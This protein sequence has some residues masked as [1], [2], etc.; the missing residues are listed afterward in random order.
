MSKNFHKVRFLEIGSGEMD[1]EAQTVD[2]EVHITTQTT[3]V[4]EVFAAM[5]DREDTEVSITSTTSS[6]SLL[7]I[8]SNILLML[9]SLRRQ[10][11]KTQPIQEQQ[12]ASNEQPVVQVFQPI[13]ETHVPVTQYAQIICHIWGYPNHLA[14]NCS[15]RSRGRRGGTNFPF[16]RCSKN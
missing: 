6:H 8:I 12:T 14:T 2:K 7:K 13:E 11:R 1:L 9:H 16:Q 5:A 3:E 10:R 4:E 15:M